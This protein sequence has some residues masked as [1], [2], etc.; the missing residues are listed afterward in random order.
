M[1][2]EESINDEDDTDTIQADQSVAAAATEPSMLD[3]SDPVPV[4]VATMGE[5]MDAFLARVQELNDT[6]ASA[7]NNSPT[8]SL[9]DIGRHMHQY[10]KACRQVKPFLFPTTADDDDDTNTTK[11]QAVLDAMATFSDKVSSLLDEAAASKLEV[12]DDPNIN[13]ASLHLTALR[14]LGEVAICRNDL[15]TILKN[16][17]MVLQSAIRGTSEATNTHNNTSTTEQKKGYKIIFQTLQHMAEYHANMDAAH[18]ACQVVLQDLEQSYYET[19]MSDSDGENNSTT[20]PSTPYVKNKALWNGRPTQDMYANVMATL[21]HA[22]VPTQEAQVQIQRVVDQLQLDQDNNDNN[23][24]TTTTQ[25]ERKLKRREERSKFKIRVLGM[26]ENVR[27]RAKQIHP[28]SP[29]DRDL[30]PHLIQ[31]YSARKGRSS[32]P[33]ALQASEYLSILRTKHPKSVTTQDCLAVLWAWKNCAYQDTTEYMGGQSQDKDG[34]QDLP[35]KRAWILLRSMQDFFNNGHTPH[36]G[37]NSD[38]YKTVMRAMQGDTKLKGGPSATT[39]NVYYTNRMMDTMLGRYVNQDNANNNNRDN[40]NIEDG[41]DTG[42]DLD[43]NFDL[44]MGLLDDND[45]LKPDMVCFTLALKELSSQVGNTYKHAHGD[46]AL[47]YL[48]ILEQFADR[49]PD[50]YALK[51]EHYTYV[52]KALD[53]CLA[54][55]EQA[56]PK[57]EKVLLR[58]EQRY[59]NAVNNVDKPNMNDNSSDDN[60]KRLLMKELAPRASSYESAIAA[61]AQ[62]PDHSKAQK[63]M[64]ILQ[65]MQER[66]DDLNHVNGGGD[67]SV[68]DN[69]HFCQPTTAC[70]N[71]VLKVCAKPPK[72]MNLAQ[73]RQQFSAAL[74]V[75]KKLQSVSEQHNDHHG[76]HIQPDQSTYFWLLKACDTCFSPKATSSGKMS[77]HQQQLVEQ[78]LSVKREDA[79]RTIFQ[80][81]KMRGCVDADNVLRQL[82]YVVSPKTYKELTVGLVGSSGSGNA[83]TMPLSWQRNVVPQ[84]KGQAGAARARNSTNKAVATQGTTASSAAGGH[85][86]SRRVN[87]NRLKEILQGGRTHEGDDEE[88]RESSQ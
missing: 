41:M 23:T 34:H 79:A 62:W 75:A 9:N 14:C 33:A 50:N 51:W 46:K 16:D 69:F 39:S 2:E 10:T 31:L 68:I 53:L 40:S 73:R 83:S 87:V 28:N 74:N 26:A 29:M 42:M 35:A 88:R 8:K 7:A 13:M 86:S 30:L 5:E 71:A 72:T 11:R 57:A 52:I 81:A 4:A 43:K 24:T 47:E 27:H 19:K 44:D 76:V 59:D 63:A 60:H 78:D 80:Q 55:P 20:S 12:N 17:M 32:T 67:E 1:I 3:D 15:D 56:G 49:E 48:Q 70:Y 18:Y 58:L 82:R 65:H 38:C 45:H 36:A 64:Y 61:Y 66:Y 54:D 22:A 84:M 6:A 37:P 21:R 85:H 25:H 77:P